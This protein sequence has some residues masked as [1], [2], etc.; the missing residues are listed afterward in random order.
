MMAFVENLA[1]PRVFIHSGTKDINNKTIDIHSILL[2]LLIVYAAEKSAA[3]K[4]SFVMVSA[5]GT[6][7]RNGPMKRYKKSHIRRF[8]NQWRDQKFPCIF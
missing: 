5:Y 1:T 6:G 7:S 3:V 2:P 4:K 8:S